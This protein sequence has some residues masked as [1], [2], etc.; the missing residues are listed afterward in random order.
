MK[1]TV[2]ILTDEEGEELLRDGFHMAMPVTAVLTGN[3]TEITVFPS[4]KELGHEWAERFGDRLGSPEAADWIK[5]RVGEFLAEFG[6]AA[7]DCRVSRTDVYSVSPDPSDILDSTRAIADTDGLTD[8]T[9]TD[10]AMLHACGHAAF[11]T[12]IDGQIVSAAVSGCPLEDGG[13]IDIGV[14]TAVEFRGHG[15]ARSN[16][17]ALALAIRA[18]GGSPLYEV[19]DDNPASIA[20][21]GRLGGQLL[22]SRVYIIGEK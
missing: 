16:A 15:F 5:A 8:R 4:L 6:F 13:E 9:D 17:A 3:S 18:A 12:V 11:G 22:E 19:E 7:G 14:E 21:A 10:F 20:L 1:R 2:S